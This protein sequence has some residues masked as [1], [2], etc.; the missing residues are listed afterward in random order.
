MCEFY[1]S[2]DVDAEELS[3]NAKTQPI[4][5][6]IKVDVCKDYDKFDHIESEDCVV[7]LNHHYSIA[8]NKNAASGHH[9][10]FW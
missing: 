2:T 4:G 8:C 6:S 9:G 7:Y 10:E 5:F 3:P 1:N